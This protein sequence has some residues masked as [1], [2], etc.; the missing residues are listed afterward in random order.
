MNESNKKIIGIDGEVVLRE[1][2]ENDL[3][4]LAEYANNKKVSVNLRDGFP[5]PYTMEDAVRFFEMVKIQKQKT[6]FAIEYKGEY[7]GN[8]SLSIGTDI[9]RKSAEIG[10]FI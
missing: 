5:H 7:V 3:H 2:N 1:F 4:K 10:Y 6:F 9:Y 8:I